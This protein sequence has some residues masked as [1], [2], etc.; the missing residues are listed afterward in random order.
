MGNCFKFAEMDMI[1]EYNFD[2]DVVNLIL[3]KWLTISG[4]DNIINGGKCKKKKKEKTRLNK[5]N[6]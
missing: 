4:Y 1:L 5:C 6:N 2:N 3:T